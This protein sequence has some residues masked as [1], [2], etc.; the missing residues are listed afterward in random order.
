MGDELYFLDWGTQFFGVP[1]EVGGHA[2]RSPQG[3]NTVCVSLFY[4]IE[5]SFRTLPESGTNRQVEASGQFTFVPLTLWYKFANRAVVGF[6]ILGVPSE[7]RRT[8]NMPEEVDKV[9]Y[10]FPR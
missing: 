2:R 5:Y 1:S 6:V 3:V 7:V 9:Q 4:V 10:L 8:I